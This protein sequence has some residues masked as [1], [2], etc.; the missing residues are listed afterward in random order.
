MSKTL[1]QYSLDNPGNGD[2]TFSSVATT[3]GAPPLHYEGKLASTFCVNTVFGLADCSTQTLPCTTIIPDS[4]INSLITEVSTS[5][6]AKRGRADNNL[7][8]SVAEYRQTADLLLKPQKTLN[9]FLDTFSSRISKLRRL[10]GAASAWLA[11]RYGIRPFISD[12]SGIIDGLGKNIGKRRVT[13]RSSGRISRSSTSVVTGIPLGIFGFS[14]SK[15]NTDSVSVRA[16]SLDEYVAD[17]TSNVGFTT[18]DL[19]TV[20]W[21]LV[22]YSF[23]ADWFANVGDV[24][25]ALAPAPGYEQLGSCYVLER[26][27]G[28]VWTC[29]NT[30][31]SNPGYVWTGGSGS[32]VQFSSRFKTR[33]RVATLP[34]PGLIIKND[35]RFDKFTRVA[36]GLSL[37]SQKLTRLFG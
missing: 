22:P 29:N 21:E 30:S 14:F 5:V 34:S 37:I 24:I 32:G 25:N 10:K 3:C 1:K 27:F 11:Y 6:L 16:M 19:I 17:L 13:Y 12:V 4:D 15:Q 7:F 35:F 31:M 8:E 23:V 26:E 2:I 18:K 9:D 36:D 28:N 33:S 20:P